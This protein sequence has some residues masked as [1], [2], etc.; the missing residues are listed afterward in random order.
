[1]RALSKPSVAVDPSSGKLFVAWHGCPT[2]TCPR[3]QVLLSTSATGTSWTAPTTLAIDPA[4][5]T[6]IDHFDVGIGLDP[7]T[8]GANAPLG[9]RVLLLHRLHLHVGLPVDAGVT[10]STDGGSSW[11]PFATVD[12]DVDEL[13]VAGDGHPGQV[14]HRLQLGRL[15]VVRF[16][17]GLDAW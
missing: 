11:S 12:P 7:N 13:V 2:S 15:P 9:D 3:N 4:G 5:L 16:G 1:M 14:P 10:V 17:S 8:S 6:T